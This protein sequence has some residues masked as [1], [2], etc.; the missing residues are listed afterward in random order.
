MLQL[1]IK[2]YKDPDAEEANVNKFQMCT[3]ECVEK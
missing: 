3:K 2:N 1:H